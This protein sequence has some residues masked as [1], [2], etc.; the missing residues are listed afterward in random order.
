MT[1]KDYKLIAAA[2]LKTREYNT[3]RSDTLT[4]NGALNFLTGY[5]GQGL[6]NDN[7]NFDRCRFYTAC[8]PTSIGGE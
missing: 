3:V 2:I 4:V 1:R 6:L 7:P 5:L 8:Q